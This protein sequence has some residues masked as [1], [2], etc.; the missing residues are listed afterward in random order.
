MHL[1]HLKNIVSGSSALRVWSIQVNAWLF[2]HS[3]H[4]AFTVGFVSTSFLF[5]TSIFFVFFFLSLRIPS[6]WV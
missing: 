2:P 3:L 4:S 5:T 6:S 1:V